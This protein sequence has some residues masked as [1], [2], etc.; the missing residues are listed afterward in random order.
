[1]NQARRGWRSGG[2][3]HRKVVIL[4]GDE[5]QFLEFC[6]SRKIIARNAIFAK[7]P[8]SARGLDFIAVYK[9]G[10][11][12]LLPE[13]AEIIDALRAADQVGIDPKESYE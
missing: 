10:T 3:T 9:T 5:R 6:R 2:L 8:S 7:D 12:Y 13:L 11:W 1:L 4:A